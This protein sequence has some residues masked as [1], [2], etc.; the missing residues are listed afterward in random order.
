MAYLQQRGITVASV[1]IMPKLGMTQMHI[2]WLEEA[3]I[4]GY[5]LM[6]FPGGVLGQRLGA[7][8]TLLVMGIIAF[9]AA[10][11]LPIAPLLL[12]GAALF[13]VLLVSQLVLGAAQGPLFPVSTG[14][15]QVW[16]PAHRWALTVG[17]QSVGLHLAE[18]VTPPVTV[19]LMAAFGWQWALALLTLPA[20]ALIVGWAGYAHNKPQEHP[21]VSE[22]ELAELRTN[23]PVRADTAI[24][25]R[26]IWIMMRNR[27]VLALT[28]S[29][30][31]MNYVY[32]L[33]AFW[34]FL[35]LVQHWHFSDVAS[36]WLAAA[37]PVGGAIGAGV[38]GYAADALGVRLGVRTGMRLLPLLA[39]PAAGLL[40]LVTDRAANAY[41]A[42]AALLVCFALVELTEGPY[43]GALMHVAGEDTM[44]ASG[45]LNSGGNA[46]GIIATPIIAYLSGQ[47]AWTPAFLIGAGCAL[48]SALLWLPVDAT[49]RLVSVP[50]AARAT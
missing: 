20:L 36:G 5:A 44:A 39:L 14:A 33:I 16:F 27:D 26:H 11:T 42:V 13:V 7:R 21:A 38:G 40:L 15:F 1:Q 29:Y 22:A 17:L 10:M 49:R 50:A 47:Q 30:L 34:C 12:S 8:R 6:Q 35:Y 18:I 46:G 45:F 23:P 28:I 48:A 2:G 43:W 24:S 25:W 3:M 32:Y 4:V 31:C 37:V 9:V 19:A 41:L